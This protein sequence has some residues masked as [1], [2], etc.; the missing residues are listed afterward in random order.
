MATAGMVPLKS[1]TLQADATAV[2]FSNIPSGYKDLRLVIT[3][4][5]NSLARAFYVRFNL[6]GEEEN[7]SMVFFYNGGVS[8]AGPGIIINS[9]TAQFIA[10]VDVLD[11]A[12]TDKSKPVFAQSG[13]SG[14]LWTIGGRWASTS[15]CTDLTISRSGYSLKPGTTL[16]LYGIGVI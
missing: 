16:S 3:G 12:A 13:L 9:D 2:T 6:A 8:S 1:Y 7:T 11:Y 4:T 5:S 10:Q 15:A 14:Q